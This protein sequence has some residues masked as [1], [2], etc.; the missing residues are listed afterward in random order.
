M[1]PRHTSCLLKRIIKWK[2][3]KQIKDLQTNLGLVTASYF[4]LKNVLYDA[5]GEKVK[6]L[7]QQPHGIDD[8][9]TT[10]SQSVSDDLPVN[11]PVPRTTTI[12]NRFEK[13]PEGSRVRIT[14][15]Q[16]KRTVTA[17]KSEGLLFMKNLNENRKAKDHVLTVTDL[18][19]RKFGDEFGDRSGI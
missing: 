11:P 8:P 9:P 17:K 15:K 10:H 19:K 7:Y 4:N 14:I 1:P 16:G 5:F 13:E 12:L 2:K 6:A 3:T 18:K